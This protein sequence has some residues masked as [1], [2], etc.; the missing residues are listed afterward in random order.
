VISQ[1]NILYARDYNVWKDLNLIIFAF[2]EL[3]N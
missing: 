1:L 2:R 3:G